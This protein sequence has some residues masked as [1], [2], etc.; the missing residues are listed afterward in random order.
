VQEARAKVRARVKQRAA[1]LKEAALDLH[2]NIS[3][4]VEDAVD[5]VRGYLGI[6][7]VEEK[8][9]AMKRRT[10]FLRRIIFKGFIGGW[11]CA[12]IRLGWLVGWGWG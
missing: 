7:V 3:D 11:V 9:E 1:D 5:D 6:E 10:R 12:S 4:M 8:L 2:E